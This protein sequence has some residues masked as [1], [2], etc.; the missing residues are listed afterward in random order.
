[1]GV[2]SAESGSAAQCYDRDL[3]K[4]S[5]LFYFSQVT[6]AALPFLDIKR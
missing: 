3:Q 5:R 1:M 4:L 2:S 6:P